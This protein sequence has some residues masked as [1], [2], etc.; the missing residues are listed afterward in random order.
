MSQ[1]FAALA[2]CL[3]LAACSDEAQIRRTLK[4]VGATKLRDE[5][6]VAAR[7]EFPREG[8]AHI[9]ESNWPPAARAFRPAAVWTEADGVYLLLDSDA[10]GERGIFLP[11]VIGDKDPLCSPKL[12]HVKLDTGVYW[13]E[14]K[15]G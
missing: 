15:R 1:W 13:F 6:I 5:S 3:A 4:A 9:T 2:L 10:G 12:K 11:R 14:R 8:A 7:N